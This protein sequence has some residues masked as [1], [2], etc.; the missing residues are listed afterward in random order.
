MWLRAGG[1]SRSLTGTGPID[2]CDGVMEMY[3]PDLGSVSSRSPGCGLESGGLLLK[4]ALSPQWWGGGHV[5]APGRAPKLVS[6]MEFE[7]W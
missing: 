5:Q 1:A 7:E 6:W 2:E 3:S 4:E